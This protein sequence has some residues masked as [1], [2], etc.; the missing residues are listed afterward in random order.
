MCFFPLPGI[1]GCVGIG[2]PSIL[3]A[4]PVEQGRRTRGCHLYSS[5]GTVICTYCCYLVCLYLCSLWT[6]GRDLTCAWRMVG[7]IH[8]SVDETAT[9]WTK[10]TLEY[11]MMY[12]G[13]TYS[14]SEDRWTSCYGCRQEGNKSFTSCAVAA[15]LSRPSVPFFLSLSLV[16]VCGFLLLPPQNNKT[17]GR[18]PPKKFWIRWPPRVSIQTRDATDLPQRRFEKQGMKTTR[19]LN[20]RVFRRS[21][22]AWSWV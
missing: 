2:S 16:R 9:A 7:S 19:P 20:Q 21:R 14:M 3:E 8:Q 13:N 4:T 15:S 5:H 18:M 10:H 17:K 1:D 6:C 12:G 22:N 11:R